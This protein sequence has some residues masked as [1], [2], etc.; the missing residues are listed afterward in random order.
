[1]K[2]NI[3]SGGQ[4]EFDFEINPMIKDAQTMFQDIVSRGILQPRLDGFYQIPIPSLRTWMLQEYQQYLK[5]IGQKPSHKI[6]QL[7]ASVQ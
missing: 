2:E 7:I 4:V 6:Q 3:I 1:M 5:I